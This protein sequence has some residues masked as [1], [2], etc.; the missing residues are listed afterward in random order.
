[1]G[2]GPNA[3]PGGKAEVLGPEPQLPRFP[4]PVAGCPSP[5]LWPNGREGLC[6]VLPGAPKPAPDEPKPPM[7]MPPPALL[8]PG[9]CMALG[10]GGVESTDDSPS[11]AELPR[12]L[13]RSSMSDWPGFTLAGRW[14]GAGR[15]TAW[16]AVWS[17]RSLSLAECC[18][19]CDCI[20]CRE[21][22]W[23]DIDV[24]AGG[25]PSGEVAA[26]C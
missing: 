20:P 26:G 12:C 23:K 10:F 21:L 24:D 25:C 19:E 6:H 1:M 14:I 9:G 2:R 4:S 7:G 15:E 17:K 16:L 18:R 3:L 5:E 11:R 13:E 22:S 8:L